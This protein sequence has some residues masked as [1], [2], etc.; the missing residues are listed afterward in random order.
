MLAGS[1]IDSTHLAQERPVPS[2]LRPD[3]TTI[4]TPAFS[5]DGGR[6]APPPVDEE[7]T[8]RGMSCLRSTDHQVAGDSSRLKDQGRRCGVI[9]VGIDWSE[10]HHDVCVLDAGGAQLASVR[11]PDGSK[12]W[13]GCT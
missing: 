2:C 1:A 4:L 6:V 3:P 8:A 12:G 10:H 7:L 11:V 9:F 13:G 5:V